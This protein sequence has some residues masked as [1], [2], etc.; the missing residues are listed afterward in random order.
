MHHFQGDP[1]DLLGKAYDR[2]V[3][4][5][6]VRCAA[7]YRGRVVLTCALMLLAAAGDLALPYLF[8]LGLDV[9]NPTLRRVVLG[10]SGLAALNL[11]LLAFLVAIAVRFAAYSGQL[12]LTSW[13]GQRLVYDLRS[14]LFRH[15][16]RLGIRYIDQRGIGSIMSRIQN[17]VSVINELFTDGLVGILSDF[18]ILFGIVAI[19]LLTNWRL[20]LLTFA[21]MPILVATVI[22][23]RRHA[24]DA[25][26]M[27]RIAIARVNANLAESIAGVRV[28]QAFSREPLNMERFRET[29]YENL[30]ASLWAA[31]LSAVL[32]PVVQFAQMLATAL[33]LGVGGHMVLGGSAFTIG[34][35]FAFVA[36]ISRFYDPISDLSQRYNTMQA[37]MVA[38][39]RIFGLEDVE[40]EIQ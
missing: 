17:D 36:Y 19:M 39:E 27:T 24:I 25:Y 5:R 1:D 22:W 21:V 28:V 31:R 16:Q 18:V 9:V 13:I 26:R 37:A 8:G 38:G 6:L 40:P 4:G 20:A 29:N 33:V 14:R 2:R 3:A 34:E 23:W 35:L 32:F 30:E 10:R 15:I 12:Y 11:L 7:P